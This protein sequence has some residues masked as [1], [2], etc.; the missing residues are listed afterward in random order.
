MPLVVIIDS[1]AN[2]PTKKAAQSGPYQ[3]TRHT[4]RKKERLSCKNNRSRNYGLG[5]RSA[6]IKQDCRAR[7]SR[8]FLHSAFRKFSLRRNKRMT[9]RNDC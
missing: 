9:P 5:F 6:Y 2:N 4:K 8:E 1:E 3:S 7:L